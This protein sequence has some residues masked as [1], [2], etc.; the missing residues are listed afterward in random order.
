VSSPDL[1]FVRSV[2]LRGIRSVYDLAVVEW[3]GKIAI[4]ALQG[5][6]DY[7][8]WPLHFVSMVG[9]Q[10]SIDAS[11]GRTGGVLRPATPSRNGRGSLMPEMVLARGLAVGPD[12][13]LW[14]SDVYDYTLAS[15]SGDGV[16]VEQWRR[17]GPLLAERE[18]LLGWNIGTPDV[19]P[20]PETIAVRIDGEGRPWIYTHVP[21]PDW[22]AAWTEEIVRARSNPTGFVG[23]RQGSP[24]EP[25]SPRHEDLYATMV[26]VLDTDEARVLAREVVPAF[27]IDVLHDGRLAAYREDAIGVP[28]IEVY[29][30]VLKAGQ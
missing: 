21:A 10:V 5:S 22:E 27:V 29:S 23:V 16:L 17:S 20:D 28:F 7:A 13:S 11:F 8:G 14:A 4:N 26:E 18:Q 24:G 2:N 1:E 19:P 3:P 30:V 6:A 9:P 12:G 25:I 15:W